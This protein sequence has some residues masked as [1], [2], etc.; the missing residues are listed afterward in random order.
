MSF[1]QAYK[2][3]NDVISVVSIPFEQGNV[4]RQ[5]MVEIIDVFQQIHLNNNEALKKQEKFC[6]LT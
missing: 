3:K 1:D 4:F 6:N 5:K 2:W